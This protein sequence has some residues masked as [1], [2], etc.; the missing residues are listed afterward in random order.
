MHRCI[1]E[2]DLRQFSQL[3]RTEQVGEKDKHGGFSC[4]AINHILTGRK[5]CGKSTSRSGYIYSTP[6]HWPDH[7][8]PPTPSHPRSI[9]SGNTPLHL[10]VMLGR[11]GEQLNEYVISKYFILINLISL[12][13]S[14]RTFCWLIRRPWKS[15]TFRA[16]LRSPRP[17]AMATGKSV[18]IC[19]CINVLNIMELKGGVW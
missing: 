2:R 1:F 11:K 8:P 10:S 16:G 5:T 9:Y 12:S 4:R 14:S 13:Q 15:K 17:S 18:S 19:L 7:W 6:F 3:L